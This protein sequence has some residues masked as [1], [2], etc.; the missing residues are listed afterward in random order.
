VIIHVAA[1]FHVRSPSALEPVGG[2]LLQEHSPEMGPVDATCKRIELHLSS[3]KM[4]IKIGPP[5]AHSRPLMRAGPS[6]DPHAK[7]RSQ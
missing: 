5:A 2:R 4:H 6:C 7:A 3:K 1:E